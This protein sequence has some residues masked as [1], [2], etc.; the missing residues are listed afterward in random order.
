MALVNRMTAQSIV[1]TRRWRGPAIVT[2]AAMAALTT[3]TAGAAAREVRPAPTTE[4]TAAREAGEPIM[5]IVSISG[6]QVTF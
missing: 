4:A 5:A 2:L 1:A 3:L 6:Q